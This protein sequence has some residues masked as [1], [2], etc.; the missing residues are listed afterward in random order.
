MKIIEAESL[1]HPKTYPA[2]YL[3]NMNFLGNVSNETKISWS[4][5]FNL[6]I[7]NVGYFHLSWAKS[8][9]FPE[10]LV[11]LTEKLEFLVQKYHTK[12]LISW[13]C[14][15]SYF[16]MKK[17]PFLP[18]K[19]RVKILLLIILFIFGIQGIASRSLKVFSPP[20]LVHSWWENRKK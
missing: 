20:T 10:N 16:P 1:D 9:F 12:N 7:K 14:Q 11:F 17:S 2:I 18:E 8:L 6:H 3:P 13:F 15:N 19:L 4:S 5:G